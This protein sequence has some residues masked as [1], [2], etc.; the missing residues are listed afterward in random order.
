MGHGCQMSD[1][2][3]RKESNV[4]VE[5]ALNKPV[6]ASPLLTTNQGAHA[7]DMLVEAHIQK[8]TPHPQ[9]ESS[10]HHS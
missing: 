9:L 2:A 7:H 6:D 4:Q 1:L 3:P 10:Y 5:V 8:E